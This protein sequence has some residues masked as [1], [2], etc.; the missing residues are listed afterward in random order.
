MFVVL[1]C[2]FVGGESGLKPFPRN[3]AEEGILSAKSSTFLEAPATMSKIH[4]V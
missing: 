4:S 2:E 1:A 3:W